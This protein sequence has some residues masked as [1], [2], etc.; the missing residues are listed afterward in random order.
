MTRRRSLVVAFL[1]L[2][3]AVPIWLAVSAGAQP[4]GFSYADPEF[5]ARRNSFDRPV[6]DGVAAR[7]WFY[8]PGPIS[9][10]LMERYV[11][12]PGGER[13]VQYF[14]K[15][16]LELNQP[17]TGQVSSGLLVR[18]LVSGSVQIG[19][20][21]YEPH[22]PAEIPFVGDRTNVWPTYAG[23]ADFIDQLYADRTGEA[24]TSVQLP[25]GVSSLTDFVDDPSTAIV[26]YVTYE[27]PNGPAGY[28]IPAGFWDF[29][30]APG[31]LWNGADYVES[32]PLVDW[33]PTYGY[34][35]SDPAWVSVQV[36][37]VTSWVMVQ[38]FERRA[39]TYTPGNEAAWRVEM[40]NV[41]RHYMEWRGIDDDVTPPPVT[42]TP[43]I[44]PTPVPSPTPPSPLPTPDTNPPLGSD[45]FALLPGNHWTY[46]DT[47][48]GQFIEVDVVGVTWD[49]VEGVGLTIRR[50]SLPDGG[51]ELSYWLPDE[52]LL[53][54]Y[55][56]ERYDAA[57]E[58]LSWEYYEPP[59][60]FIA[61]ANLEVG[62]GW[63]SN[64]WVDSNDAPLKLWQYSFDVQIEG[65]LT[66]PAGRFEIFGILN[67][68]T[69][70]DGDELTGPEE[71]VREF[72]FAPYVGIVWERRPDPAQLV[73]VE[74]TVQ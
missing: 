51:Y 15:A 53:W 6:D 44:T 50:E 27:G 28:N 2:L 20:G 41:G 67:T 48:S 12:S 39:L 10:G 65:A 69:P 37:G 31:V 60:R 43:L 54:L 62:H 26:Q 63:G 36:E 16:R 23:F 74:Y 57:D 70:T 24:V 19:D 14:D 58:L 29:M 46:Q 17:S 55:G 56:W 38:L 72:Y 35:I 68:R 13:L 34:P 64:V 5:E 33:L 40:G 30:T 61:G 3:L 8:G 49:M 66:V 71:F 59:V 32:D 73:L 1:S 45:F 47:F 18:E 52:Q 22:D 21:A 11:E 4:T 7:S 9:E 42:E 25:D